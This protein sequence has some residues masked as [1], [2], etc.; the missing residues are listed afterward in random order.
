MLKGPVLP[1][2]LS[3]GQIKML[4]LRLMHHST[5]E[6]LYKLSKFGI[7]C[8]Y[9]CS[10][11]PYMLEI[12]HLWMWYSPLRPCAPTKLAVVLFL[13]RFTLHVYF[14]ALWMKCLH[15]SCGKLAHCGLTMPYF[16]Q[17]CLTFIPLTIHCS[18]YSAFHSLTYNGNL[19]D[20]HVVWTI[21]RCTKLCAS[22]AYLNLL[23]VRKLTFHQAYKL[24]IFC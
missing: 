1:T 4:L 22:Y 11:Q 6:K 17:L 19:G 14:H 10:L 2:C 3:T 16:L 23:R 9:T 13:W 12:P 21:V 5:V 7:P 24:W 18:D 15:Y 20:L 8:S